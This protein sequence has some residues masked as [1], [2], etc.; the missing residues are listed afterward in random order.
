M[1]GNDQAEHPVAEEFEPLIVGAG[2]GPRA[3]MGQ[4]AMQALEVG[5]A[6]AGA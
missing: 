5:K 4:R 6:M 3:G 1:V 2:R